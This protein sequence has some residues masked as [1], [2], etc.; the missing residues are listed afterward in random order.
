MHTEALI[1]WWRNFIVAYNMVSFLTR[2]GFPTWRFTGIKRVASKYC[3][4]GVSSSVWKK[5]MKNTRYFVEFFSI[6]IKR[7]RDVD[8]NNSDG[9]FKRS[10]VQMLSKIL[11]INQQRSSEFSGYI[12]KSEGNANTF[13][14]DAITCN[15][16]R[17][18]WLFIHV[19]W[20]GH[21]CF[22]RAPCCRTMT[23]KYTEICTGTF[24]SKLQ[25]LCLCFFSDWNT[26]NNAVETN[27]PYWTNVPLDLSVLP[28]AAIHVHK[29]AVSSSDVVLDVVFCFR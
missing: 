21:H 15:V 5:K 19:A 20:R 18:A 26:W 24:C 6:E 12:K 11:E 13:L 3:F 25:K 7:L 4:C 27:S 17:R 2:G 29:T 28:V 1:T 14:R 9:C 10:E 23:A 22:N 8:N 16:Y